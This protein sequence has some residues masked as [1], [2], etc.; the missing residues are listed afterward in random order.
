MTI[1]TKVVATLGPASATRET[2]RALIGA[3][4]DVFRINFSHG[5]EA[6]HRALLE[7]VRAAEEEAREPI[8]VMADLCGPKIRVAPLAGDALDLAWGDRLVI[9]RE[10]ADGTGKRIS[11]TLPELV[12]EV[13]PGQAIL[14]D[15][16]RIRLEVD[17]SRA[18]REVAC[19]VIVGGVLR[20]G[21][22]INLPHTELTVSSLTEKDRAD[23]AWIAGRAIDY[24][25]LSFVRTADDVR[26]LRDLL[27]HHGSDARVV[28][29]VEKPQALE[30]IEAIVDEADA[31]M[32]ARGDLGV[33]MDLP[34]VP[35]AQ[36]R[37][38]ALCQAA[39]KPCIIATQMLESM[40]TS[41]TPTRAEV[42]DVA[43]AV[44]DRADAV[45]LSGETAVGSYPVEAVRMMNRIAWTVETH[46]DDTSSAARVT[47]AAEPTV[48]ALACAVREIVHDLDVAAVCVYTA[49]GT[50]ARMLSKSRIP[51]PI[52]ALAP[53][54]E[55]VR[56]LA[57]YYG[58][59]AVRADPPEHTRD[60]LALAS[61]LAL[62][63]ELAKQGD[64][65]VVLSGRPIARPGATNTLVVH[66]IG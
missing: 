31:V 59:I 9:Q 60:V 48:A 13:R 2:I 42:S 7:E 55:T 20:S 54:I 27:R 17:E 33:E 40:T 1:R 12:D 52:L 43:N 45:M 63:L 64:R 38:A 15:D 24:V 16:G 26:L 6:Q 8:A 61:R 47:S 4:C 62:D 35:V 53:R 57:L 50:T 36:K 37:I 11:T 65:I 41:P 51:R 34:E 29:K 3:G 18:P 25:A 32:V 10:R 39:A 28:A 19:R 56:R 14:L 5:T 44:M 22:G 23:V 66:T 30:H 46:S 49:T 58:T 21:K